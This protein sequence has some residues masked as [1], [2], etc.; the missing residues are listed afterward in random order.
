M[1][2]QITVRSSLGQLLVMSFERTQQ[3]V[4]FYLESDNECS[5]VPQ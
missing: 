2:E 5:I 4:V 1:N 3:L